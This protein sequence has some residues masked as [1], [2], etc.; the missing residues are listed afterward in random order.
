MSSLTCSI[1]CLEVQLSR[2]NQ[3]LNVIT[4]QVWEV[5]VGILGI[6]AAVVEAADYSI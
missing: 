5:L 3:A 4:G 1:R 6:P 2:T